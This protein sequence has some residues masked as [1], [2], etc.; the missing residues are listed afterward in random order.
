MV[1]RRDFNL[2][3]NATLDG[4]GVLVSD[5]VTLEFDISATRDA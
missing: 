5:K 2:T 3:W 1:N 4:G